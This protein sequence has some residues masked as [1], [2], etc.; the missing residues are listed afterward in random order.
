MDSLEI[1]RMANGWAVMPTRE[2]VNEYRFTETQCYVFN[3]WDELVAHL[4]ME[5][6]LSGL[7]PTQDGKA[8]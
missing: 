7:E 1:L 4:K 8:K 5:L 6:R 2:P 3:S